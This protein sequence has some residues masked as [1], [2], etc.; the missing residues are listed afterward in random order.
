MAARAAQEPRDLIA[1]PADDGHASC[2]EDLERPSDVQD[3]LRTRADDDERGPSQLLEVGADVQR[4]LATGMDP[5]DAAGREDVD[6]G[7]PGRDHR[8]RDRRPGPAGPRQL[9]G[10]VLARH[11]GDAACDRDDSSDT[12]SRPTWMRPSRGAI[13][14][15]T[16]PAERTAA[17]ARRAA[18]RL[19]GYGRP[20]VMSVD[21]R[22]TTA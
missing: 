13:V 10:E 7:E 17:S 5:T 14:A 4:V 3:G 16:A 19:S 9:A 18:A 6:A 22:A 2:L 15:G 1:L 21:S 8:G 20:W 12:A 11:L